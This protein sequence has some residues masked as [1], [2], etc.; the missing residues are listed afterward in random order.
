MFSNNTFVKQK[1]L[2][3]QSQSSHT[4]KPSHIIKLLHL[5]EIGYSIMWQF[6][7]E[8]KELPPQHKGKYAAVRKVPKSMETSILKACQFNLSLVFMVKIPP[9]STS[10]KKR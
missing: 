4:K 8:G 2:K 5:S 3:P 7:P 10:E 1:I 6:T 9:T